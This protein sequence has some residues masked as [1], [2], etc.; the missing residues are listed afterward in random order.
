MGY[1]Y[2]LLLVDH[3]AVGAA[4]DLFQFWM[5][6]FEFARVVVAKNILGHHPAASDPGPYDGTGGHEGLVVVAVQ[7]PDQ[8]P[9][10]RRFDIETTDGIAGLEPLFDDRVFLEFFYF[11]D[12]DIDMTIGPDQLHAFF[13]MAQSALAEHI[14]LVQTDIFGHEH[15]EERGGKSLGRQMDGAP[16]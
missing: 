15:V 11:L 13:D 4:D 14:Q 6:I 9:H 12:V 5:C 1:L 2:D 10:R 3:D 7:L 16:I 8:L